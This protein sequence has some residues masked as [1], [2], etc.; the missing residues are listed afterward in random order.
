MGRPDTDLPTV[1]KNETIRTTVLEN[2]VIV[3][4]LIEFDASVKLGTILGMSG[5][6]KKFHYI[7]FYNSLA[8]IYRT[9][10]I[11]RQLC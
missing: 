6:K 3:F 11:Y 4:V 9:G 5:N 7:Q 1:V 8:L 2:G 10:M